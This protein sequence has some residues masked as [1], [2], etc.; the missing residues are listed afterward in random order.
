MLRPR[1][2]NVT[3][4]ICNP[5]S[6]SAWLAAFLK[7][8]AWTMHDPLAQCESV[9]EL[10]SKIDA[11]LDAHPEQHIFVA[12]TAAVLLF[13][14]IGSRFPDARYLIVDRPP[15]EW[16]PSA[17]KALGQFSPRI[18]RAYQ[19]QLTHAL[20]VSEA[21]RDLAL[22]VPYMAVDRALLNIWR[23]VGN[24]TMLCPQYAEKMAG[25]N[26]QRPLAEQIANTDR[27]KVATL[28]ARYL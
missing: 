3:F 13:D 20:I 26:I 24:G 19:Q 22:Y 6:R 21:R 16:L 10:G 28:L 4:L 5:R 2:D 23:F 1:Y 15:P 11:I 25:T 7:P 9:S 18:A 17:N 8:V 27:R 12:D 14:E